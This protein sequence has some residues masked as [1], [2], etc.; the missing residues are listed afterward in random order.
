MSKKKKVCITLGNGFTIDYLN[1]ISILDTPILSKVDVSN[2]FSHGANLKWPSNQNPGFLSKKYTPYLWD[3]GARPY[4][5]K[6]ETMHLI[7]KIVT[8]VNVYALK[9][10]NDI[11]KEQKY[12]LA[13]K[14][15]TAYLKYLFIYFNDKQD[16][17]PDEISNWAW[18]IFFRL[19]NDSI[20]I[21]EVIVIT[22]NYDVWLERILNKLEIEFELPPMTRGGE[23]CKFRI[24]KPHGSISFKYKK[25]LPL[26]GFN[27]NY[28]DLKSECSSM[29]INVQYDDLCTNN[30]IIFLIPPAGDV[31][32]TKDGWNANIR[33]IYEPKLREFKKNDLMIISGISYWHVDRAEIDNILISPSSDIDLININPYMDKYFESVI[34]SLF[35]NYIH[36][37]TSE[38]LKEFVI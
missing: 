26:S 36:F 9:G 2:L 31:N 22:Y 35:E 19:L 3:L 37:D 38:A 5:D 29:D 18:A 16:S 6:T 21:E 15:L 8:S 27:I 25:D 4:M 24:F 28:H 10:A 33:Q 7:E 1:F 13:Y 23:Q 11:N 34:N 30:P 20:D 32:R 14:E 12:L 17:I